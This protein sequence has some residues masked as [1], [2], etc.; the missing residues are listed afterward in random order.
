VLRSESA[1]TDDG[2]WV[3]IVSY[4]ALGC[5]VSSESM[6]EAVAEVELCKARALVAAARLGELPDLAAPVELD[7]EAGDLLV[8]AGLGDWVAHLDD[9]L[10]DL[11][12]RNRH[13]G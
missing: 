1:P 11:A 13:D 12:E 7:L 5:S 2:G 6:V 4:P 3:R 8:A 10:T 9:D